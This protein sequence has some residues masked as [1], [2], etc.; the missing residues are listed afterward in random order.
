MKDISR[1]ELLYSKEYWV[2]DIQLKLFREVE[3]FMRANGINRTQLAERLGCSK[4]YVSQLLSGE[5]DNKI[6]KFVELSLAVGKIPDVSF[7]DIE[8]YALADDRVYSGTVD[9]GYSSYEPFFKKKNCFSS[10]I[11]DAA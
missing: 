3:E 6:S 2:S 5:Y 9:N 1:K 4:G 10:L 11:K 7:K 8:Q